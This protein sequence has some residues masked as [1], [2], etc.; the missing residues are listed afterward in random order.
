MSEEYK[1]VIVVHVESEVMDSNKISVIELFPEV[2]NFDNF[3]LSFHDFV[4]LFYLFNIWLDSRFNRFDATIRCLFLH[5][6]FRCY[7][8]FPEETEK[9]V[10]LT[11][12]LIG[13]DL[14]KVPCQC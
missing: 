6:I 8:F 11:S 7:L 3:V 4:F 14:L 13:E 2:F 5:T 9:W 1:D 12:E 10:F